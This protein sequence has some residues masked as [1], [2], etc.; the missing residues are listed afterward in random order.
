MRDFFT[1]I[2][3]QKDRLEAFLNVTTSVNY[4]HA[5][6]GG[7]LQHSLKVGNHS[8]AMLRFNEPT[9]PRLLQEACFAGGL[10][11][12]IGKTYNYL[13]TY[14]AQSASGSGM[15]SAVFSPPPSASAGS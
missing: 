7:L 1:R 3:E 14:M 15:A 11:H 5:Y 12:D 13:I 8:V 2:L 4:R 9:V 6:S 10:W